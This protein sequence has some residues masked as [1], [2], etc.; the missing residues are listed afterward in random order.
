MTDQELVQLFTKK[1][2]D[3]VKAD[4]ALLALHRKSVVTYTDADK[5]AV[6]I[7]EHMAQAFSETVTE[8]GLTDGVITRKTASALFPKMTTGMDSIVGKYARKAQATVNKRGGVGLNVLAHNH[9]TSRVNGLIEYAADRVYSEIQDKLGQTIV[10]YSQSVT[11]DTLKANA[12]AQE[13]IGVK[14]VIVREYDGVGLH[15]G[16]DP[17]EWCMSRA[18][19]WSYDEANAN[20][21]FERHDGCGCTI[22]YT[23]EGD[24]T[25][26]QTDWRTNTWEYQS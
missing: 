26:V 19:T 20:G 17:C 18:G 5:Y 9:N 3:A 6:K 23:I 10:N 16:K 21:V 7:G 14:A 24:D 13:R 25:Q 15:D 11:T 2:D 1:Y 4:K 8:A 12:E 22:T